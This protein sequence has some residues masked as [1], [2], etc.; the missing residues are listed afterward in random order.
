[1]IL[2]TEK[3]LVQRDRWP[4]TGRHIL[5]QYDDDSVIVYQAYRPAIGH[6]AASHG[7]FGGEFSLNRRQEV[8]LA[9]R[10]CVRPLTRSCP[11]PSIPVSFPRS[12]TRTRIG[13]RG[14][15]PPMFGSSGIRTTPPSGAKEERRA[16]Q[17]GLRG[18]VLRRC[19]REWILEIQDVSK[20]V[21]EQRANATDP[22]NLLMLTFFSGALGR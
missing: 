6:F 3:Y 4:K 18:D 21:A 2:P 1:M 13:R 10:L 11:L 12:I 17:L 20:F 19:A 7:Y 8:V 16:I 5:A 14:S 15:S 22:T 9:V